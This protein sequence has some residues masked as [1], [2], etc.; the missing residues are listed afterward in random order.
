MKRLIKAALLLMSCIILMS[1]CTS[2]HKY[3]FADEV[4]DTKS[5]LVTASILTDEELYQRAKKEMKNHK[6]NVYS[7]T[8]IVEYIVDN[9]VDKYPEFQSK[10]KYTEMGDESKYSEIIQGM[11]TGDEEIDLLISHSDLVNALTGNGTVYSYFPVSCMGKINSTYQMPTAFMLSSSLFLYD[12]SKGKIYMDNVWALTEAE[13]RGLIL[14]KDP[15]D[16]QVNMDFLYMLA[17]PKWTELLEEAYKDYY[18]REWVSGKY[19]SAAYEWID[20]FISNCDFSL[21][22]SSDIIKELVETEQKKI[23][24]VGYSKLRKLT[25]EEQK[26]IGVFALQSNMKGFSG[27]AFGTYATVA[28]DTECPYTCALFIN[29]ILSDEGF[30]GDGAWNE[31]L[32]YYSTNKTIAKPDNVDYQLD[33]WKNELVIEDVDYIK[34]QNDK[35]KAFIDRCIRKTAGGQDKKSDM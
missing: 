13:W 5:R 11:E 33:F 27:F 20:G 17:S 14:M 2:F 32:G 31:Y 24:L 10:I 1:G 22:K 3:D 25:E 35:I 21:E 28:H 9:F 12:L 29:Y 30:S 19:E 23:A 16:E 15:R 26:N 6:M 8:T 18:G 7:T 4:Q 34:N